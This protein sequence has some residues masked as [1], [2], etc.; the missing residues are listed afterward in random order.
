MTNLDVLRGFSPLRLCVAY[1]LPDGRRTTELPAFELDGAVPEFVDLPGFDQDLR[2]VR[3]FGAL[4]PKA[5]AYVQALE[6]HT[7]LAIRTISVGPEREQ[8]ILR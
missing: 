6:R 5:Q 8:L 2:A 7:G 1:R 3:E 4:P